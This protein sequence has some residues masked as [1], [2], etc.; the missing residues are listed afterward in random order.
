MLCFLAPPQA[1]WT[2]YAAVEHALRVDDRTALQT[3][4]LLARLEGI[5]PALESSHAVAAAL[6]EAAKRKP[7]D[8]ILV[9]LSGRGDKDLAHALAAIEKL[10]I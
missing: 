2:A 8:A 9:C 6:Q 4:Q 5:I 10:G 1:N 7:D 3:F